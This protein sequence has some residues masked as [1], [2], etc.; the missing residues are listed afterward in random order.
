MNKMNYL[1]LN[2]SNK[3]YELISLIFTFADSA[4]PNKKKIE[5]LFSLIQKVRYQLPFRNFNV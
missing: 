5:I 1:F 4:A 3:N 2:L